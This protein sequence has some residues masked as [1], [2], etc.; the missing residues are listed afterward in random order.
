MW[1]IY[2]VFFTHGKISYFGICDIS[3]DRVSLEKKSNLREK[4]TIYFVDRIEDYK[5]F[6]IDE[7]LKVHFSR[8]PLQNFLLTD[9]DCYS[10]IEPGVFGFFAKKYDCTEKMVE[11]SINISKVRNKITDIQVLFSLF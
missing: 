3:K 10:T 6:F 4:D 5:Y 1:A 2:R 7:D 9:L 8:I 11:D